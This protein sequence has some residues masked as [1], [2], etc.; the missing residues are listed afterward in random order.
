LAL[1]AAQHAGI[2]HRDIKPANLLISR[3]GTTKLADL[4]LAVMR[5]GSDESVYGEGPVGT[6]AYMPPEQATSSKADFRS[7]IYSLG[8]TFYHAITGRTLFPCRSFGEAMMHLVTG[9]PKPPSDW[10]PGLDPLA[11][12]VIMRMVAKDPAMRYP[13]YQELLDAFDELLERQQ[14]PQPNRQTNADLKLDHSTRHVQVD[15]QTEAIP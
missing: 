13:N 6:L 15:P 12:E 8:A 2:I 11:N 1:Q 3:S 10:L 4:G 7:D 14:Q 9:I 5:Q